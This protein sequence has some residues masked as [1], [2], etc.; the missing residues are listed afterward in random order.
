MKCKLVISSTGFHVTRALGLTID[1][2]LQ[3]SFGKC[4]AGFIVAGNYCKATCGRCEENGTV[5]TNFHLPPPVSM[6]VA[7]APSPN[8]TPEGPTPADSPEV[9]SF[10]YPAPEMLTI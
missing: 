10:E 2:A 6:E 5:V 9:S 1:I 7:P 4:E 8:N 3:K